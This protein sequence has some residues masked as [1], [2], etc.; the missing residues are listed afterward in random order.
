[1]KK[2]P[3]TEAKA[4]L[5][6]GVGEMPYG[7]D[8]FICHTLTRVE[9]YEA[10]DAIS[11]VQSSLRGHIVVEGWLRCVAGVK[12]Y[13]LSIEVLQAYRLRWLNELERLWNRGVRA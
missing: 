13:D 6:D 3:F 1:M 9:G 8:R 5:W 2:N 4:F 11:M 10:Q 12:T 7:R